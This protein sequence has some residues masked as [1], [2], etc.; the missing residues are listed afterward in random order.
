M[1]ESYEDLSEDDSS[2]HESGACTP[3]HSI[4]MIDCWVLSIIS[5]PS[6]VLYRL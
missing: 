4:M 1:E 3:C 2:V 5:K 6:V